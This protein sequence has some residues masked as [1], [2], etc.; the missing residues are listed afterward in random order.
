MISSFFNKATSNKQ[1]GITEESAEVGILA[2]QIEQIPATLKQE[3]NGKGSISGRSLTRPHRR[4]WKH[5]PS[6]V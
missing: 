3:E 4:Y 6:H 5:L 2:H 1:F